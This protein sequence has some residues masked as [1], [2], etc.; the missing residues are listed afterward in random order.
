[1]SLSEVLTLAE[2]KEYENK[3]RQN[4]ERDCGLSDVGKTIGL[5][6][7]LIHQLLLN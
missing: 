1:M 4:C 5:W 3:L 2:R 7:L 6:K